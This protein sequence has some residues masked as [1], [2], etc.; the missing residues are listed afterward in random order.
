MYRTILGETHRYWFRDEFELG[1]YVTYELIVVILMLNVLIAVVG[2]SYEYSI[3][4]ARTTFIECRVELVVELETL[5]LTQ[6]TNKTFCGRTNLA[7]RRGNRWLNEK[8]WELG[9]TM[10]LVREKEVD[11][12]EPDVVAATGSRR[13]SVVEKGDDADAEMSEEMSKKD[14]GLLGFIQDIIVMEDDTTS[15]RDLNTSDTWL[16]RASTWSGARRRSSAWRRRTSRTASRARWRRCSTSSPS[17]SSS[18]R[19]NSHSKTPS[20]R[21][22]AAA[23]R[24]ARRQANRAQRR[25]PGRAGRCRHPQDRN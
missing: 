19:G 11:D 3:I 25:A 4:R 7:W 23:V 21:S 16:G 22:R 18:W 2:D 13:K 20:R 5:G 15:L 12:D 6:P 14:T 8:V 9:K 1:L 24:A 17:S 10:R